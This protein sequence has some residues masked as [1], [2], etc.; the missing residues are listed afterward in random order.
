[1]AAPLQELI[2]DSY[3]QNPG[4]WALP[5]A[6]THTLRSLSL[7]G[8]FSTVPAQLA[9]CTALTRFSL[10]GSTPHWMAAGPDLSPLTALASLASL[11]LAGF[12]LRPTALRPLS[13]LEGLADLELHSCWMREVP[14][15]SALSSLTRLSLNDNP[16]ESF[17][18][19]S[20]A[21]QLLELELQECSLSSAP[22]HITSPELE[23]DRLPFDSDSLEHLRPLR[24]T[25]AD[26][27]FG[28]TCLAQVPRVLTAD[29][30]RRPH[31]RLIRI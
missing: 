2:I 8:N 21:P 30:P 16:L 10:K 5:A 28:E 24:H 29:S 7:T 3:G 17:S 14:C 11:R 31:L 25:L 19:L 15:L 26:L 1:V 12:T 13:R 18:A 23:V 4:Q 9:A 6:A 27:D 22:L 20:H